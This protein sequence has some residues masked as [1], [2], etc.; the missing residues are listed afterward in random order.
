MVSTVGSV[1]YNYEHGITAND[2]L[3]SHDIGLRDS[4][5]VPLVIG[6]GTGI[7]KPKTLDYCKTTDI[8][9]TL[10]TVLGKKPHESVKGKSLVD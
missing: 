3:Y 10:V 7:L 6:G 1:C 4:M 5:Y 9:P 2:H 8:V